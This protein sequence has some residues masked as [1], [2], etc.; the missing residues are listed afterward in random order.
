MLRDNRT[1]AEDY[2]SPYSV[3]KTDKYSAA[4]NEVLARRNF[5]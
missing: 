5:K 4:L 1:Y 3:I 2:A